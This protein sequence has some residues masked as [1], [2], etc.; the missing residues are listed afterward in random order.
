MERFRV[1]VGAAHGMNPSHLVGAIANE[2]DL[3]SNFIGRIEIFKG[4][5][6]VDLPVGM[7]EETFRLLQRVRV[8]NR[9]L[10][11]R[12]DNAPPV[13]PPRSAPRR[14]RKKGQR[15]LTRKTHV[16]HQ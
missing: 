8:C 14:A 16:S 4:H 1:Q 6:T 5:S 7:P 3:S 2:A 12:K 11:I 15:A 9:R 13:S 10:R